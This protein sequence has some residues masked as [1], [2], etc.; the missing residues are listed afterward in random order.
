M[1]WDRF[2]E[3]LEDQLDSEWEAERAAL[4][5]EAERLRLSRLTLRERLASIGP[6]RPVLDLTDGTAVSGEVTGVGADWAALSHADGA[7]LVPFW[8]IAGVGLAHAD[9]LR[10]ARPV[11]LGRLS[12]RMTFGYAL[13]DLA[14]R[15]VTVRLRVAGREYAG[16]LDRAA[17]DHVDLAVH[18]VSEP[19][20]ARAITG[21]RML[22]M[23]AITSVS[24]L[25]SATA[26]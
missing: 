4:D 26:T 23:P 16:T 17:A 11:A 6:A 3:D 7:V 8:A 12:E 14:R 1:R 18:D 19:R 15:R 25:G 5:T 2:F 22:A 21:Y 20:R 9:L 24:A 10:T 13:R